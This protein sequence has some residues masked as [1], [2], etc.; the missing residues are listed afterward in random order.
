MAHDIPKP[1]QG[2]LPDLIPVMLP[3]MFVSFLAQE[4]KVNPHYERVKAESEAWLNK[5]VN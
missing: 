4:P 2:S 3:D 1:Q 5:L